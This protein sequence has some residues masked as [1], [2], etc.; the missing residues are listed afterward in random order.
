MRPRKCPFCGEQNA[1]MHEGEKI[2]NTPWFFI[3]CQV[4][5]SSGPWE[6]NQEEALASWNTRR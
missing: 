4:C 6:D 3:I 5:H 1:Q 2:N